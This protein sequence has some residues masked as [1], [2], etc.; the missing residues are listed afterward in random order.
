M[1]RGDEPSMGF[2]LTAP[3]A[4]D[5]AAEEGDTRA[6]K[7]ALNR[8]GYYT[9]HV[10]DGITGIP[11]RAVF[12]ALKAFQKDNGLYPDGRMRPGDFTARTLAAQENAREGTDEKYIWHSV[13]DEKTRPLHAGFD[14]RVFSMRRP[15]ED[16]HPGDAPNCRC[17]ME[18]VAEE[19]ENPY[20]DAISPTIGPFDILAGGLAIRGSAGIS[21]SL[22]N[23]A[24]TIL[25]K[26]PV[27]NKKQSENLVRFLK[28]IPANSR[29]SVKV[30]ELSD[31]QFKFS[32]TS[33]GR[34]PG[35]K[36]VYEK[37][38]DSEGR[39]S[40]YTKTTFDKNGNILHIKNKMVSGGSNA[41]Q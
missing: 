17:W 31:G 2:H 35:S 39:T 19:N 16:G 32:A 29:D 40:G 22:L 33:P 36:A 14:G 4:A 6:V 38:V 9:P 11:D 26:N 21:L 3:F 41:A 20:P 34:V 25:S 30:T 7:Q 28:K 15:S 8:L 27:L 1:A 12:A 18:R 5:S 23:I 10:Q 37:I 13:R 24:R